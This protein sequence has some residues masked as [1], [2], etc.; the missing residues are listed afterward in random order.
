MKITMLCKIYSAGFC[1]IFLILFPTLVLGQGGKIRVVAEQASIRI[2]P[3]MESDIIDSPPKGSEY[4]VR[5]KTGEWYEIQFLSRVGVL[6]YGYIHEDDVEEVEAIKEEPAQ[7]QPMA[8]KVQEIRPPP[9]A[10]EEPVRSS[11]IEFVIG[12]GYH[13]GYGVGQSLEYRD[14]FHTSWVQADEYG[15]LSP[16]IDKPFGLGGALHFFFNKNLGIQLRFDMNSKS[17][18]SG[19]SAYDFSWEWIDG[20][21]GNKNTSWEISGDYLNMGLGGNFIFR[22]PVTGIF[23]PFLSGGINYYIGK[24]NVNTP[25]GYGLTW[26]DETT[27]YIDYFSI[28]ADISVS[29]NALGFNAGGGLNIMFSKTFGLNIDAR[30]FFHGE[31]KETWHIEP[32]KYAA[33]SFSGVSLNLSPTG[34]ETFQDLLPPF[35]LNPSYFKVSAG[36]IVSF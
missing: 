25:V 3:V 20:P 21:T 24:L 30:Y 12:G 34:A 11:R 23:I 33:T 13:M 15:T 19:S 28:P 10:K 6:V 7:V 8:E 14:G 29:S 32:G 4:E 1:L 17:V 35:E 27:Y 2:K 18:I 16:E 5:E 22:L 9:I 36:L 26:E 31:T